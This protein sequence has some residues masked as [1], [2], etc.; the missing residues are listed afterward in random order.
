M[1]SKFEFKDNRSI[2]TKAKSFAQ[3]MLFWQGR[4]KGMIY[5]RKIELADLRYIF[6]PK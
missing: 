6:C 1:K 2:T 4:K 5:T 3:S